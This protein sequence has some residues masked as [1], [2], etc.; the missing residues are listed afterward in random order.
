[1]NGPTRS[2]SNQFRF[3]FT[4]DPTGIGHVVPHITPTHCATRGPCRNIVDL[5]YLYRLH[6]AVFSQAGWHETDISP[7]IRANSWDHYLPRAEHQIR[8]S[9]RPGLAL[10]KL[11]LLRHVCRITFWSSII[12]PRLDLREFFI[13]ERRVILELV[14]TNVFLDKERRH[15]SHPIPNSCAIFDSRGQAPDLFICGKRHRRPTANPMA[16]LATPLKDRCDIL[17]KSDRFSINTEI[18]CRIKMDLMVTDT[19]IVRLGT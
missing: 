19:R 6:I 15:S 8:F 16:V 12:G 13:T 2:S 4:Q 18:R 5:S 14:D 17:R 11:A 3:I 1:M 9:N 7:P 10:G